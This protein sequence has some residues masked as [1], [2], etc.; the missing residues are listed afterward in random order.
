MAMSDGTLDTSAV[1]KKSLVRIAVL[2][3][4]CYVCLR[5]LAGRSCAL[6]RRKYTGVRA[7]ILRSL[8][9]FTGWIY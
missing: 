1:R 5:E 7:C 4:D 6:V 2:P 8:P 3:M 9:A